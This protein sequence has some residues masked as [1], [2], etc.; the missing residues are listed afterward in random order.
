M[1]RWSLSRA[2]G[3]RI[4]IAKVPKNAWAAALTPDGEIRPGAQVAEITKL[5]DLADGWPDGM[6]LL[7]RT[8]P[9]HPRHHKQASAIEKQR[10]QRFQVV[11]H[12]LPGHHYPRLDAFTRN[13]AGVESVIKDAKNLGLRRFPFFKMAANQARCV[14][15][16]LAA[17]LVAWL[18]LLALDHHATLSKASPATL[19]DTLLNVPARLARRARKRLIRL[20]DDHPHTTDLILAWA[21]TAPSPLSH[22]DQRSHPSRPVERPPPPSPSGGHQGLYPAPRRA[23]SPPAPR[24]GHPTPRSTCSRAHAPDR[25]RLRPAKRRSADFL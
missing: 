17:E 23:F 6:R 7:A 5:L 10:G 13:H 4:A 16:M 21:K 25:E 19:R 11:A 1:E 3:P 12:D 9:L 2:V 14:A 18:R 20:P 8:E 24:N 22:P 15:V